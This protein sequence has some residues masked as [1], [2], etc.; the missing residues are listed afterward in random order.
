S[1][2]AA[3]SALKRGYRRRLGGFCPDLRFVYLEIDAET[4]RRRVGSRKGHFMPASLVDSQ[5]ATLEAPTAD[6]PALTVD[7][8][9]RISNI[10]AGVLDELRTKTS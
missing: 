9:G 10:V 2:V 7:G 6:E 4:A 8:T 1:V 5:F 3:C